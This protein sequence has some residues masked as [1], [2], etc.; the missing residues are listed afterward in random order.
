M[1]LDRAG[2]RFTAGHE[3]TRPVA[4]GYWALARETFLTATFNFWIPFHHPGSSTA[5]WV[6]HLNPFKPGSGGRNQRLQTWAGHCDCS[7]GQRQVPHTPS[8]SDWPALGSKDPSS[9]L[10]ARGGHRGG[11]SKQL[12]V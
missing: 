9:E 10:V 3:E 1:R 7:R 6:P 8:A 12:R 5:A 2:C 4:Q 11:E